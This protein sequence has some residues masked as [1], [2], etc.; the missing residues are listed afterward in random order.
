LNL[1]SHL[2]VSRALIPM[3]KQSDAGSMI[4]ISSIF[5]R[6]AGGPGLSIYNTTKSA[7]ISAAKI[8]AI[9]LAEYGIRVNSVAPGSI[10]FEGGSWDKRCKE[11]PEGMAAFI[12]QNIPLGRFGRADEVA[13]VV[14]FLASPRASW[15]SGAS[16]TVDG[17][18]SRSL[19]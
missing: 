5:G 13:D 4:F 9:E 19:I 7:L 11:D 10:R 6:E 17:V 3:I 1:T 12:K 8:M 2:R 14:T 15:V 16:L 18:Q